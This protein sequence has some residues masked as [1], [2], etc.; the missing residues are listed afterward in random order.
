[1]SFFKINEL[2]EKEEKLKLNIEQLEAYLIEKKKEIENYEIL[3]KQKEIEIKELN[4]EKNKLDNQ[5]KKRQNFLVT[6]EIK[7]MDSLSGLE[8]EYFCQEILIQ[9]GFKATVTKA[10]GDNGGDI[11]AEKEGVSYII[12]CKKYSDKVGNK[13][14]QEVY[15]AKGIYN[16]EKAIVMTNNYFTEQAKFEADKLGIQ[17]WNRDNV[18][19]LI[20]MANGFKI[21]NMDTVNEMNNYNS[22]DFCI[23]SPN[24]DYYK[25]IAE[26]DEDDDTDPLLEDAIKTVVEVGQVST[27]FIQRRFKVGYARAGRIID[28]M[29]ARGIVSGYE[30]SNPR[31]ALITMDEYLELKKDSKV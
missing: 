20:E 12:Q 30:G 31:K 9:N 7:N 4:D 28:Q 10:S 5:I 16:T 2:R 15:A 18:I 6:A 3:K 13:A 8:F 24:N 19:Q 11:K 14:V 23:F 25:E 1:M 22:V 21:R 26:I 17:L 29:E 27:S